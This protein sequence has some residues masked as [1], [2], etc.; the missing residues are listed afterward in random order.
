MYSSAKVVQKSNPDVQE[1]LVPALE[2]N[3]VFDYS[4]DATNVF[5]GNITGLTATIDIATGGLL[6]DTAIPSECSYGTST[7]Q[8]ICQKLGLL[9]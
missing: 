7:G 2:R 3:L 5:Q 8:L 9:P 4:M 1:N 6:I